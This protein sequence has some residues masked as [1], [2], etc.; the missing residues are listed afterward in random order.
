[1]EIKHIA[2]T[3]MILL[4]DTFINQRLNNSAVLFNDDTKELCNMDIILGISYIVQLT[5]VYVGLY[6]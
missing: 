3:S 2:I 6:M 5:Q 4:F 1:M